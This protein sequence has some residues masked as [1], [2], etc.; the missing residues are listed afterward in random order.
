ML[1]EMTDEERAK[2]NQAYASIRACF[3]IYTRA[4]GIENVA[5]QPGL[6]VCVAASWILDE[7]RHISFHPCNELKRYKR[8][9]YFTYWFT[10]IKPIQIIS[11]ELV[12]STYQ[13]LVNERFALFMAYRILSIDREGVVPKEFS[14]EMLYVLRYRNSTPEALFTTMQ[15]LELSARCGELQKLYTKNRRV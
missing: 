3:N 15:L 12:P 6:A 14:E 11:K 2:V 1:C 8:A 10:W 9:A 4:L 7:N 13:A 5:M